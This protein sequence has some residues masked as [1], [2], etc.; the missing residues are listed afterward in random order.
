MKKERYNGERITNGD[1]CE[2]KQ[3][4]TLKRCYIDRQTGRQADGRTD[5]QTDRQTERESYTL[6][7]IIY[8]DR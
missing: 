1:N 2:I 4:L 7:V 3:I 5:R 8:I 6:F